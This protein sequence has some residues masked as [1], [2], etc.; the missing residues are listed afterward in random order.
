M[1]AR[2]AS[3]REKAP[4][5]WLSP[6]RWRAFHEPWNFRQVLDCANPLALF[7]RA[8]DSIGTKKFRCLLLSALLFIPLLSKAAPTPVGLRCEY[9]ENPQGIDEAHPRLSWRVESPERG[10]KQTAYQIF[11]ASSE[12]QLSSNRGD[13]WDSGKVPSDQTVN[14]S[15]AGKPLVSQQRCFWKVKVWDK[16]GKP[17]SSDVRTWSMGFMNPSDW[18]ADYISFRD[19][20]PVFTNRASLFLPAARQYRKQFAAAKQIRRATVYATALGIY[21]LLVNGQ[22]VADARF[23][24]GWTDYRQRAYYNTYDVTHLLE[25]GTNALGAWVADGWY[26]GYVGFGLLTGIGTERIGRYTYGKTP[27]FMAQLEIE[28]ADGTRETVVTDKSW[29]VTGDGPIQQA[30]FLMGEFYD[31]RKEMPGWSIAGFDDSTWDNAIRAEENGS[32]KASFYQFEN[33]ASGTQV[34]VKGHEVELGFKRPP[35]LE[36]FPGVPVRA[37]Q[38]I[39]PVGMTSPE[40]GVYIFNLGQNIAGVIRLKVKGA[41]A[42]QVLLRYGEMLHPDGRLMR[43]NLRKARAV[44]YYILRGDPQGETY[45]PRFTFHGFQYVEVTGFPGKPDLDTITGI[46]IHSDTPL[47]SDFECSDP[48]VN[49]LFKNIV[50]TQRANFIDLPTDC[51][52]RDER[53]GWTGDAQAYIRAATYNADAS[54]FYTKWIRELMESQRP[55]GTFPGYAPFPFQHGWDFG[56]AWCDAGVICP[57]TFWKVYGDTNLINRCWE[58]MTKFIKW[59]QSESKGFLGVSH[60]NNWGDWLALNETTPLDYIDTVY[61]AYSTKLMAEMAHA[62]QRSGAENEY[63]ELFQKI[64]A[65]F[66]EK[67]VKADGMLAVDTQTAYALGLFAELIPEKLRGVAAERVGK[68]IHDNDTRMATGFLGTRPLLPVLT[69]AGQNDL[70]VRLLQS[71]KFPSWGY[72]IEQGATTIWERWNSFTRD[73]GF[74]DASM[75]SFSHYAFGAVC[76]WMFASLAGI[77]TDGPAYRKIIIR[78]MPPSADTNPDQKPIDWVRA[79]YDSIHGRIASSWKREANG[80]SLETTIPANTTATVYLP[81]SDTSK[82]TESGKPLAQAKGVTLVE[83]E[84]G[85]AQ[86]TIDSGTYTFDARK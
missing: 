22:T 30:D 59:R 8:D 70:A 35:Q 54:A 57:W 75:N 63:R 81:A 76:E 9:L 56:T 60:G 71:R 13:L 31:A 27:A 25:K 83:F 43:E 41:A 38:E 20:T 79:H 53:F 48:M 5:D 40:D 47:A 1:R 68:K 64:K 26:S 55:S 52:Q 61:F 72:E 50:W 66:G 86:L 44:D 29:K 23:A 6:R 77:D 78:P 21:E 12:K 39:K 84:H 2:P 28:Y 14:L 58:P 33:P 32:T 85:R 3:L 67:Y 34:E 36:A 18:K 19:K 10:Q 24:P 49:R 69:A 46:V 65:A 7:G 15:Y 62:T 73:K 80:F 16:D 51:P 17:S 11:V 42:T 82:I 74:G 4:E 37:I 45:V